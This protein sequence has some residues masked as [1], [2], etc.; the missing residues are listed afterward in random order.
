MKKEVKQLWSNPKG[1]ALIKIGIYTLLIFIIV[2]YLSL[3]NI[4][5]NHINTNNS[6]NINNNSKTIIE[7]LN[8][9][10]AFK[11]EI[12]IEEDSNY[13]YIY[14]GKV[15]DKKMIITKIEDDIKSNYYILNDKYY[16]KK[17]DSYLLVSEKSLYDVIDYEYL[18]ID[19]IKT[20]L[21]LADKNGDN[22]QI[23][24]SDIILNSGSLEYI[25]IKLVDNVITIDYTNLFKLNND[26]LKRYIVKLEFSD[27][28]K[29]R[30]EDVSFDIT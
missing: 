1:K 28:D 24:V 19:N 14:E 11:Y 20:Y 17:E 10:Y 13:T 7:K 25:N 27:I 26:K 12:N 30:D 4:F 5:S 2:I 21:N 6:N 3:S 9:N 16:L 29:I 23:K 15:K 8:N 18:N 22:Y